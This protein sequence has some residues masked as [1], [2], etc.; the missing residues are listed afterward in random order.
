MQGNYLKDLN[1]LGRNIQNTILVDNSPHA[2]GYQIDNGIPIESWFDDDTD[3]ELLKLSGFLRK[4]HN[5]PDVRP[6]IRDHFKTYKLIEKAG[7]IRKKSGS[8]PL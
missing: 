5:T 8:T 3:T 6:I 4:L 1:V 2:Y 7:N